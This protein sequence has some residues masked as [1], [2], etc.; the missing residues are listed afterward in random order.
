MRRRLLI[1]L[2]GG[3]LPAAWFVPEAA[4]D[5]R[6]FRSVA[7]ASVT[8]RSAS[9]TST[10]LTVGGA[11]RARAYLRFD[12]ELPRGAEILGARLR[13]AMTAPRRP[14]RLRVHLLR[15]RPW[16]ER[17][18]TARTAPR[19][20]ALLGTSGRSRAT[21]R[22]VRLAPARLRPG[23][24]SLGVATTS[25]RPVRVR[26]RESGR[27]PRLIVSYTVRGR[28]PGTGVA[29]APGPAFGPGPTP[30]AAL[31]RSP[32]VLAAGDVQRDNSAVNP[33]LPLLAS[34]SFDALLALGDLQYED[35]TLADFTT[36]Y[37]Q[38]WGLPQYKSRTYPVPGNHEAQSAVLTNYCVY[39]ATGAAVDPCPGGRPSYSFGLG[40]WHVVA[41]DSSAGTIDAVQRA[42]LRA[43]LAAH[44]ARCTLAFWHHPRYSGG[45]HGGLAL[46]G[47]WTDLMAAGVDVV[48][49]GHDHTYQRFAA[50]NDAGQADPV[51]GI[52][53]FVVG[54]GGRGSEPPVSP[55]PWQE[56]AD[57]TTMGLLRLT[58]E[59][60]GY[61][62]RFI[63]EPG[64][65][66]T[67]SGAEPCR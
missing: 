38:T 53:S 66:F 3:A 21:L 7:D 43:D 59:P 20:G 2:L 64:R 13:L 36:W 10:R 15:D 48:L 9:G 18:L 65:T 30:G 60:G 63:P 17:T 51:G 34:E 25:T 24:V 12:V 8:T 56:V 58:L 29:A 31:V 19:P 22:S 46:N 61:T 39:F 62:W 35:G 26:S 67:D 6:T 45:Q 1:A 41:L 32:V 28:A 4:A 44:P 49:T 42:W 33:T 16:R 52:R 57:D 55:V 5:R 40:T 11:A 23:R 27:A 14:A 54:T 47:V 50:M 37:A